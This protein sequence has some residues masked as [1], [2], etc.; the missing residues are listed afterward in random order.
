MDLAV[1]CQIDL[2]SWREVSRR[3]AENQAAS[4]SSLV[5]K[6]RFRVV[7][8]ISSAGLAPLCDILGTCQWRSQ[9]PL[10]VVLFRWWVT[11]SCI[12]RK[13]SGAHQSGSP[14]TVHQH[15]RICHSPLWIFFWRR[16][17]PVAP[18]LWRYRGRPYLRRYLGCP[19]R[20][21]HKR[22]V[23]GKRPLHL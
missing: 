7:S 23:R 11:P 9:F 8:G 5:S 21:P 22:R 20:Q 1:G 14:T 18:V 2:L 16:R 12:S 6:V 10:G 17:L 13:K 15:S 3:H 19:Q 4:C